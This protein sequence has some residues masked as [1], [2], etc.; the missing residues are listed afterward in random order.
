MRST[1]VVIAA[2]LALAA[3]VSGTVRVHDVC[4]EEALSTVPGGLPVGTIEKTFE[5]QADFSEVL[6]KV[7]SYGD[8]TVDLT[9]IELGSQEN[10]DVSF[11]EHVRIE[12]VTANG[13]S[14]L[15]GEQ[16][17]QGP[18]QSIVLKV[19]QTSPEMQRDIKTGPFKLKISGR[20]RSP[21]SSVTPVIRVCGSVTG[22][23]SYSVTQIGK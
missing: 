5:T 21:Q 15:L 3:C 4:S 8:V 1:K 11:V 16:D 20:L 14:E 6:S 18:L 12:F 19:G 7:D 9:R 2:A 23:G 13:T 22:E 10:V 17:V